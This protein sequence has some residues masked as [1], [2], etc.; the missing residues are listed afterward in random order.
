MTRRKQQPFLY[1]FSRAARVRHGSTLRVAL[2]RQTRTLNKPV[3]HYLRS[4]VTMTYIP[5][6]CDIRCHG[7]GGGGGTY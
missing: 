3:W 1:T 2:A 7:C 4:Q 5:N 6:I